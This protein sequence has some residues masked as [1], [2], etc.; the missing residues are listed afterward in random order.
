MRAS[1]LAL[2]PTAAILLACNSDGTGPDPD[3]LLDILFNYCS[4][5]P[6]FAAIQTE[7][8]GPWTS[9]GTPDATGKVTV[10][11]P[12]TFGVVEVF[13]SGASYSTYVYYMSRD[14]LAIPASCPSTTLKTVN[15]SITPA[16]TGAQEAQVILDN[17]SAFLFAGNA[18]FQ[19]TQVRDGVKDLMAVRRVGT[20]SNLTDRV[21][22]R[23][24]EN[25][26][27]GSTMTALDFAAAPAPASGTLT[28]TG[29]TSAPSV[30]TNAY[31]LNNGRTFFNSP[32]ATSAS[33]TVYGLPAATA[34]ATDIH[35]IGVF[36]TTATADRGVDLFRRTMG[37]A[38][39]AVGP[40]AGTVTVTTA[41]TTPKRL[42]AQ[43]GQQADYDGIFQFNTFQQVSGSGKYISVTVTAAYFAGTPA[44]WDVTVPDFTSVTGFPA[45]A[46][47]SSAGSNSWDVFVAGETTAFF[48]APIDV[49]DGTVHKWA[50]VYSSTAVREMPGAAMRVTSGGTARRR[51]GAPR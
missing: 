37:D 41:S 44:T 9:I 35:A 49:A 32:P 39:I 17:R 31:T 25:P 34:I 43:L 13:Q 10:Q 7:A 24:G 33:G 22:V 5:P 1:H 15:G 14:E 3:Q 16:L 36:S 6:T 8:D 27:T 18:N 40:L 46:Q 21:I 38:T 28:I 20:G 11:L 42:R 48:K 26:A 29:L 19:L 50:T 2:V 23:R 51:P 47:H 45:G 12:G 4:T 30:F